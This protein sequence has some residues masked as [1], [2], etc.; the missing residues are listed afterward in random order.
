[1]NLFYIIDFEYKVS[2]NSSGERTHPPPGRMDFLVH[3]S[4]VNLVQTSFP[5]VRTCTTSETGNLLNT[6]KQ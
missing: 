3:F 2:L 6:M 4:A 1:M 5:S